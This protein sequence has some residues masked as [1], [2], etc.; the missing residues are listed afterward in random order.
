MQNLDLI[1]IRPYTSEDENF[2]YA[3][4]LR[5]L[6]YGDTWFN[7]IPKEVFMHEYHKVLDLIIKT[8]PCAIKIACLKEDPEVILGYAI[9]HITEKGQALD[10][11]FIKKAW[12]AIGIA[13]M[14]V[15]DEVPTLTTVTHLSKK[16][17]D[18]MKSKLPN[19]VFN[20]FSI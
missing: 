14:L 6:Y 3:S 1:T 4:W 16:G 11:V 10:W 2:V 19:V 13:K 9:F 7:A 12:R 15:Q 18:I 17:L 8:R 5:G 20:P